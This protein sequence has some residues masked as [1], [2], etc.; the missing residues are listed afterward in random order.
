MSIFFGLNPDGTLRV[1]TDQPESHEASS[2]SLTL[3]QKAHVSANLT[4][5]VVLGGALT[6]LTGGAPLWAQAASSV[7]PVPLD[8]I[9]P[10]PGKNT[11]FLGYLHD[12]KECVTHKTNTFIKN[13]LKSRGHAASANDGCFAWSTLSYSTVNNVRIVV[14]GLK[15]VRYVIEGSGK[16]STWLEKEGTDMQAGRLLFCVSD[17]TKQI[18]MPVHHMDEIIY[19]SCGERPRQMKYHVTLQNGAPVA[20]FLKHEESTGSTGV[21]MPDKGAIMAVALASQVWPDGHVGQQKTSHEK[22]KWH[23]FYTTAIKS[24]DPERLNPFKNRALLGD[25]RLEQPEGALPW[26]A[27]AKTASTSQ[28]ASDDS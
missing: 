23:T 4:A 14:F 1:L 26:G 7:I 8:Y 15:Q 16:I 18:K 6:V 20:V 11:Y 13:L 2:C 24:L 10:I 9:V 19:V 27:K 25:K 21:S 28:D 5:A 17:G 12:D 22:G 3:S